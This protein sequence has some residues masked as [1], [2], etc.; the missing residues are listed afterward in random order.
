ML[1]LYQK[2][3]NEN[4]TVVKEIENTKHFIVQALQIYE[5]HLKTLSPR[6]L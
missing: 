3:K 2:Y 6:K 1:E 4:K 5:E